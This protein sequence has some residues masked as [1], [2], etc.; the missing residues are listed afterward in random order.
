MMRLKILGSLVMVILIAGGFSVV[1]SARDEGKY[2]GTLRVAVDAYPGALDPH[3]VSSAALEPLALD[4]LDQLV[5]Y[6]E[7]SEI[8]PQLASSWDISED[9][10]TY[11]FHLRKGIT[12]H[13]GTEFTAEDAKASIM[14]FLDMSPR[15]EDLSAI[16]KVEVIDPA[17]LEIKLSSRIHLLAQL[18]NPKM[19]LTMFPKEVMINPD[20][21]F[22]EPGGIN[23]D[24][25][26][27]TGPFKL[28]ERTP[29][30]IILERFEDYVPDTAHPPSGLGGT[31]IA[32]LDRVELYFVPDATARVAG[33]LTGVYDLILGVPLAK[34]DELASE[35]NITVVK[36]DPYFWPMLEFNQTQPPTNDL[37]IRQA[38]LAC[39]DMEK[40]LA[41]IQNGL[42]EF[43]T[44]NPGLFWP[45]QKKWWSDAGKEF[46]NQ[47]DPEKAKALMKEAGYQGEPIT[48]LTSPDYYWAQ[49]TA[50]AVADQL[51]AVGFNVKLWSVDWGSIPSLQV[52][53]Q[54]W[55]IFTTA[56]SCRFDLSQFYL[57][58]DVLNP[59][60]KIHYGDPEITKPSRYARL[61]HEMIKLDER[62]YDDD[63]RAAIIEVVQELLYRDPIIIKI[64]DISGINAYANYVKG[65]RA[66]YCP[67]FWNVWLEK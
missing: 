54:P 28:V 49:S 33:L 60:A 3:L 44:L 13:N 2:G 58:I 48:I 63:V 11:T 32:Y 5:V 14:R 34:Y 17:T 6:D 59:W 37:R 45:N 4:C 16:E 42:E 7:N 23:P 50:L 67:T 30:C 19:P 21:T 26:I 43:Y 27:G 53:E 35:P 40:I 65:Y 31:K 57:F 22:L 39:L 9:G 12:F 52:A 15:A 41:F 61:L 8:M 66:V 55:N 1:T 18:A 47:H 25:F 62:T 46:Y 64:G 29:D 51:S 20:G 36:F 38:I 56:V 24:N 10:L